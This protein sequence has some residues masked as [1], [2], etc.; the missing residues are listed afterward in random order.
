MKKGDKHE[1]SIFIYDPEK[2]EI[3]DILSSAE[4]SG[5]NV[6]EIEI[7]FKIV[8]KQNFAEEYKEGIK[9]KNLEKSEKLEDI[10]KVQR[11]DEFLKKNNISKSEIDSKNSKKKKIKFR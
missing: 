4:K 7:L 11:E 5:N 3:K 10:L 8:W 2:Y 6:D 9:P 1:N